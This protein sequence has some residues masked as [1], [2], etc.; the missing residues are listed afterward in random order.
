MNFFEAVEKR[1]SHKEAFLPTPIPREHIDMIAKA[2]LM[3][4]SGANRQTV[5][6]VVL[7]KQALEGLC[8]ITSYRVLEPAPCAIAILT[9]KAENVKNNF[10]KEDYSAAIENMLL[11]CTALGYASLWLDSPYFDADKQLAAKEYFNVPTD[12]HL[13]AVIPVGLPDGPGTRRE[14][15]PFESRVEYI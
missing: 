6:L 5:R 1:Y 3:A 12:W 9:E 14:K 13:W 2:G 11:A 10:E 7:S 15:M 4:P 8:K